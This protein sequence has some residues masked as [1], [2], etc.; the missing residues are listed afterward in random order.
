[1]V[2]RSCWVNHGLHIRQAYE[3]LLP[4]AVVH[5]GA[6][7]EHL[8]ESL[9]HVLDLAQGSHVRGTVLA[10]IGQNFLGKLLGLWRSLA[11][12]RLKSSASR[13]FPRTIIILAPRF[14]SLAATLRSPH[15]IS[16]CHSCFTRYPPIRHRHECYLALWALSLDLKATSNQPLF[17][18]PV[19]LLVGIV[20]RIWMVPDHRIELDSKV[21]SQILHILCAVLQVS[22]DFPAQLLL[23][24]L[25][26]P[27]LLAAAC[28]RGPCMMVPL[29]ILLFILPLLICPILDRRRGIAHSSLARAVSR[30]RL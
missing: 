4:G 18:T 27:P 17:E 2:I 22:C 5:L 20:V 29:F 11:V 10:Q 24:I 3:P 13:T 16:I 12:G 25:Q 19:V 26:A 14:R 8:V 28:I 9:P 21:G 7:K 6:L 1:M 30:R 23:Q 15:F